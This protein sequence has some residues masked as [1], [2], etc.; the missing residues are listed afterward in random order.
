MVFGACL[1]IALLITGGCTA[2]LL[3]GNVTS[4]HAKK[5]HDTSMSGAF[6][7]APPLESEPV[8]VDS[9]TGVCESG[10]DSRESGSFASLCESRVAP[11]GT[12]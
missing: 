9:K 12:P 2:F 5:N 7:V 10:S 1:Q 4:K 8:L 11:V 6:L 3:G